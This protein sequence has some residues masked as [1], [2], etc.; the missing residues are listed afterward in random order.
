[1]RRVT[2]ARPARCHRAGLRAAVLVGWPN[3]FP[4]SAIVLVQSEHTT[5]LGVMNWS[6]ALKRNTRP[7]SEL[8]VHPASALVAQQATILP[9]S[10][11]E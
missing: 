3:P 6:F 5:N 7:A 8:A 11:Q 2:I 4:A 10:Q 1:M 9:I